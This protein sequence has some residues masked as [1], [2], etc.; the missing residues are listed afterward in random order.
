ML[1]WSL[2]LSVFA[3]IAAT[4]LWRSCEQKEP[5]PSTAND[6][7]EGWARA[8]AADSPGSEAA[9]MAE[10]ILQGN[11]RPDT[12][13][14][15]KPAQRRYDWSWI[16]ARLGVAEDQSIPRRSNTLP[17]DLF[18]AIDGYDDLKINRKDF[19][20]SREWTGRPVDFPSRQSLLKALRAGEIGALTEGPSVGE[21]APDFTLATPDGM[22]KIRLHQH[23]KRGKPIVLVFGNFTCS[24][25]RETASMLSTIF[26]EFK[27]RATF[28]GVYVR[29]AHPAG[30]CQIGPPQ[31]P[32]FS[33]SQPT[34]YDE[35]ASVASQC[36][37]SLE[38]PFPFLVDDLDD[39]VGRAYSGMPARL[40][41]IDADGIV[42]FKSARAPFG[43]RPREM[44]QALALTLLDAG[45]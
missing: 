1:R 35:R 11:L 8:V 42:T 23:L 7:L 24:D 40:Y 19:D 37:S 21:K 22:T 29:E 3:V 43:L 2:I 31:D 5:P 20:W 13:W 30:G 41:V 9:L 16:A 6:E 32:K 18:D 34:T 33:I 15:K 39:A 4:V 36:C 17:T 14:F 38:L 45:K 26:T 10:A 28:L 44:K 25:F 12:G 27:D